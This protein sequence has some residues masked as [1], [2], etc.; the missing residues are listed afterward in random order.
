[1]GVRAGIFPESDENGWNR[2]IPGL[3]GSQVHEM[4]RIEWA[5]IVSWISILVFGHGD[6]QATPCCEVESARRACR[7]R[8]ACPPKDYPGG[9]GSSLKE[10]MQWGDTINSIGNRAGNEGAG[11]GKGK[12]MCEK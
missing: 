7:M 4:T 11:K 12:G 1:M 8:R 10:G 3:S 6:I 9:D 5:R 2:S